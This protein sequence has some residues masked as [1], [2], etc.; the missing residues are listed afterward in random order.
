MLA[1]AM[2]RPDP[3]A[4]SSGSAP[5]TTAIIR[6]KAI[7]AARLK[8]SAVSVEMFRSSTDACALIKSHNTG[9]AAS[10]LTTADTSRSARSSTGAVGATPASAAARSSTQAVSSVLESSSRT[11]S[12]DSK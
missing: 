6:S 12:R 11:A 3:S 4:P 7:A 8:A 10:V 5:T 9:R 2:K 1:A